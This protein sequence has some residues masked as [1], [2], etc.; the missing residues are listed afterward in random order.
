MK[1]S[2]ILLRTVRY[3]YILFFL[4][5]WICLYVHHNGPNTKL[6]MIFYYICTSVYL[7]RVIIDSQPFYTKY[8]GGSRSHSSG[9][10]NNYNANHARRIFFIIVSNIDSNEVIEIDLVLYYWWGWY[11]R[12]WLHD[13][14]EA[15]MEVEFQGPPTRLLCM[16]NIHSFII[17]IIIVEK[18]LKRDVQSQNAKKNIN[19]FALEIGRFK[20]SQTEN[21]K[22]ILNRGLLLKLRLIFF[23]N[24]VGY[25]VLFVFIH[26]L[27]F[28]FRDLIK[29][30]FKYFSFQYKSTM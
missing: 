12:I 23:K 1:P 5:Y 8:L 29:W 10:T 17:V 19:A 14:E 21:S 27:L 13:K 2:S 16:L 24:P 22:K 3:I 26:G 6:A 18:Y 28:F 30:F 11:L 25:A 9:N 7:E 4:K 20:C 15:K